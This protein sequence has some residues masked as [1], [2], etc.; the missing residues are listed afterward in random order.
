MKKLLPNIAKA[1]PQIIV[2]NLIDVILLLVFFFM[3]TSS[4]ARDA[5]KVP[6]DL[7]EASS[8]AVIEGDTMTFQIDRDGKAFLEGKNVEIKNVGTRVKDYVAQNHN[9]P[10]LVEADIQ[11]EYG[12]V[13]EILD[14]IRRAGGLNIGLSTKPNVR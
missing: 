13:V 9:R 14:E 6:I 8:S 12:Q 11:T 4:F 1:K 3:I 2:T 7:P 5:R 10:V